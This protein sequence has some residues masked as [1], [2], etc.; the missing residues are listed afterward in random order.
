MPVLRLHPRFRPG[1]V[2]RTADRSPMR[3]GPADRVRFLD[4]LD[5]MI[6]ILAQATMNGG[7]V[8]GKILIIAFPSEA[9]QA[10]QRMPA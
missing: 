2:Q 10:Q 8:V 1:S 6:V 4:Q 5:R 9:L 7:E 3:A